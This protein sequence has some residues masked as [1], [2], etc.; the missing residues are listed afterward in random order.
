M[1]VYVCTF[2]V[3]LFNKRKIKEKNN[4][5]LKEMLMRFQQ[6]KKNNNCL[7]KNNDSLICGKQ[8]LIHSDSPETSMSWLK[9]SNDMR[10]K[11]DLTPNNYH[12]V[13]VYG[14]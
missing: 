10:K 1:F 3:I 2:E 7:Q 8:W 13:S 11:A 14:V 4:F 5:F 12:S 6:K 9:I